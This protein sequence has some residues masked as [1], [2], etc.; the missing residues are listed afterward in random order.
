MNALSS[1]F[2]ANFPA[3]S[4]GGRTGR[5]S[6]VLSIIY[7]ILRNS[8]RELLGPLRPQP[9]ICWAFD[10]SRA[11]TLRPGASARSLASLPESAP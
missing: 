5:T 8:F 7:T 3:I 9:R 10:I 2:R 11:S 1:A 6:A 4:K